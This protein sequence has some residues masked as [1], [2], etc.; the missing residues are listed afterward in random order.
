MCGDD[1]KNSGLAS[2][3]ASRPTAQAPAG[4]GDTATIPD[5]KAWSEDD[6]NECPECGG[7][8]E[9]CY[10]R[11]CRV[12]EGHGRISYELLDEWNETNGQ[13]GVGA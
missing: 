7:I 4:L 8:G 1:L 10:R 2:G 5:A 6:A 3:R 11:E 9:D 13:F 12:C